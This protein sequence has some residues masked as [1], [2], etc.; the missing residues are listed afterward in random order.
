[1]EV[2]PRSAKAAL[3]RAAWPPSV[4]P[5][6]RRCSVRSESC[7]ALKGVGVPGASA[8]ADVVSP[9]R[10]LVYER[11]GDRGSLGARYS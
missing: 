4:R 10:V 7:C 5:M 11:D 2:T 6:R 1:M 9:A 3:T 8:A